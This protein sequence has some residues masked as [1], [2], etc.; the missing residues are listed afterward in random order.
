MTIEKKK[1]TVGI[2]G[3]AGYTGGEL[4]RLL[5]HHPFVSLEN[6]VSQSQ[7]GKS[8][9]SK[10]AD[11]AGETD[12]HFTN[13]L[14]DK[15][16]VVFIA[17]GHGKTAGVLDQFALSEKTKIIDLSADFRIKDGI[18]DFI[19]GLPELNKEEITNA[20]AIANCGCFAT[21][22]QL[23]LLPLVHADVIKDDIHIHAI[24]GSTGAGQQLKETSHF[25]N[26]THNVS[27]Y[28]PFTHQHL[29]EIKQSF[30]QVN[31]KFN[32]PINFIPVR[33][34]FSRGIFVTAYTKFDGSEQEANDLFESYYASHPYTVITPNPVSLKHVINTNK[35]FIHLEVIQGKLLMHCVIDNLIKGAS[36]Q[37]IQNMNLMFGLEETAGL[38]LK[39]I[40]F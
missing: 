5:L 33:G 14:D 22:I 11:L 21:A 34:N 16:D 8:V 12:L 30:N 26:R 25:S 31:D 18:H 40:A 3:G 35:C 36:G 7:Y 29:A 13:H 10:H 38:Q 1:I 32:Y 20:R 39:S 27:V 37:A 15:L 24:T 2:V 28:K 17:S 19:Y 23:A 4:I 6:V 9:S